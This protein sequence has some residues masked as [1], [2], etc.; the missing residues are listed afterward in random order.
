M[1]QG[2]TTQREMTAALNER[3]DKDSSGDDEDDDEDDA[4]DKSEDEDNDVVMTVAPQDKDDVSVVRRMRSRSRK[5]KDDVKVASRRV[6]DVVPR[7]KDEEDD[8]SDDEE[9]MRVIDDE[10][11]ELLQNGLKCSSQGDPFLAQQF[12]DFGAF[13]V[14]FKDQGGK[15]ATMV[16]MVA[17]QQAVKS[18]NGSG[19][20]M[21]DFVRACLDNKCI[22]TI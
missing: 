14:R 9:I 12:K 5:Q 22:G 11:V 10:L 8:S 20:Q 19:T 17:A 18:I 3:D 15:L 2:P 6:D 1:L 4:S 21:I 16:A 13:S 7:G